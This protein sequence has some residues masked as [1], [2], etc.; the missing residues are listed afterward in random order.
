[1]AG[2]LQSLQYN[3]IRVKKGKE[4]AKKTRKKAEKKEEEH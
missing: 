1:M 4:Q 2:Q 3:H